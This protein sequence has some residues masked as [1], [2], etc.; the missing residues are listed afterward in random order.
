MSPRS[1]PFSLVEALLP[2]GLGRHERLHRLS[3]L[4]KRLRFGTI[5]A[6]LRGVGSAGRPAYDPQRFCRRRCTACRTPVITGTSAKR[7][8]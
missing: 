3:D 7:S 8:T 2:G 1:G 5:L 6:R 4:V